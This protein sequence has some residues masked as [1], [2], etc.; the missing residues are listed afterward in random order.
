LELYPPVLNL[1]NNM[2]DRNCKIRVFSTRGFN[3][4]MDK[5][6]VHSRNLKIYRIGYSGKAMNTVSRFVNY[7]CFHFLTFLYLLF[8]RPETVLYFETLS[9]FPAL[10]YK[11]IFAK[12]SR[13]FIHYHEYTSPAEFKKSSKLLR[14][15]NHFEQKMYGNAEWISHIN[16]LR[17]QQF[18][19]D[20]SNS[21]FNNTNVLCNYPPSK[22]SNIVPH[23]SLGHPLRLVYVGS[24]GMDMMYTE[25][26]AR[27]VK[28]MEGMV[29]WDIYSINPHPKVVLFLNQLSATNITLKGGVDYFNL[30]QVLCNYDVG[31]VLYKGKIL[32]QLYVTPNKLFEYHACGLDVWFPDKLVGCLPFTTQQT[33]PK[34]CALNFE[35]LK[36][37]NLDELKDRSNSKLLHQKYSC[38]QELQLLINELEK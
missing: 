22:W 36:E 5:F 17:L 16:T 35:C 9:C 25:E 23:S 30:P 34:I 20:Y 33:Y 3:L 24:I 37:I 10:L 31:L 18:E 11:K 13:L 4:S 1:I 6:S 32:S 21:K 12:K 8:F 14:L 38:E 27:W 26:F 28:Q 7:F 19:K 29:I 2:A 15:F